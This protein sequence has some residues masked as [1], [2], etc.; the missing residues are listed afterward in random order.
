MADKE[1]SKLTD[2]PETLLIP[3]WSRAVETGRKDALITDRKAVET[4]SSIEYDFSKFKKSKFSQAGCCIRASLI[5]NEVKDFLKEYPDAV[6]VH[7]GA[8]LDA[9]YERIGCPMLTHWYDLDLGEV[10]EMRRHF[11]EESERNTYISGSMFDYGWIEKVKQHGKPVLIVVEGVLMY[12]PRNEVK[13]F[14]NELCSRLG[15]ATVIFDMLVYMLV[16]NSKYHDSLPKMGKKVEF[17]WSELNVKDM[18]QWN[19]K[20][21]VEKEYYMSDYERGR[22]PLA[23]RLMYKIPYFYKRMNQRVERL[24]IG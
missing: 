13:A 17:L 8:G 16:G 11:L 22:Y 18:E 2:V 1:V 3:L 21:H 12:F 19:S 14:F 10:I 6:V 9:R 24:R 4:M 7:L 23:A 5:D 20:I 15:S